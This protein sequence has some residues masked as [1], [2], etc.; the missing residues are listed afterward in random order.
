MKTFNDNPQGKFSY[1][2]SGVF[3]ENHSGVGAYIKYLKGQKMNPVT[4]VEQYPSHTWIK[5]PDREVVLPW[6]TH[7]PHAF[8]PEGFHEYVQCSPTHTVCTDDYYLDGYMVNYHQQE[9]KGVH[10]S[11][12]HRARNPRREGE[13]LIVSD[14][15]GFQIM[16]GKADFV[17]PDKLT[18]WYGENVDMG[19]VMDLPVFLN[20][21]YL[22]RSAYIQKA[23]TDY[24]LE[25]KTDE[26][27]LLNIFHGFTDE[28][29]KMFSEIVDD[30]RINNLAV[31]GAYFL[32]TLQSVDRLVGITQKYRPFNMYHVLGV[33]RITQVVLFMRMAAL[34]IAPLITCDSSSW[35]QAG[36][37][38]GYMHHPAI[39]EPMRSIQFGDTDNFPTEFNL[40]PCNCPVCSSIKYADVLRTL[41]G[42]SMPFLISY[43]N[44]WAMNQYFHAMEKLTRTLDSKSLKE[45]LALQFKGRNQV[46]ADETIRGIDYLDCVVE[47]G[48]EEARRRYR[49]YLK[50]SMVNALSG[51][52][53]SI[54]DS[55]DAEMKEIMLTADKNQAEYAARID[56]VMANYVQ[57]HDARGTK[58]YPKKFLHP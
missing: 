11:A 6:Q 2:P 53:R 5:A 3:Y 48:L 17:S 15:G 23:N 49:P 25:H 50:K 10:K 39:G 46:L 30:P 4:I 13:L 58:V 24:M 7:M 40:L 28:D 26:L 45:L 36:I 31:G 43:H 41:G 54:F 32:T 42:T 29:T 52:S 55:E 35:I 34:G 12:R 8:V 22:E 27:E 16:G 14:S 56:K 21:K 37:T 19:V 57:W 38:K 51:F 18:K 33:S 44:F 20:S 9:D 47:H 1:I